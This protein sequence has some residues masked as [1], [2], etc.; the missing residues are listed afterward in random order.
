MREIDRTVR[1]KSGKATVIPWYLAGGVDPTKIVAPYQSIGVA[2]YAASLQNFY[3]PATHALTEA[4]TSPP[5]CKYGGWQFNKDKGLIT[6]INPGGTK[7]TYTVLVRCY[8]ATNTADSQSMLGMYNGNLDSLL[9]FFA[10][11]DMQY[12]SSG[13]YVPAGT[14]GSVG[15]W[16]IAGKRAYLNGTYLGDVSNGNNLASKVLGVGCRGDGSSGMMGNIGF[17]LIANGDLSAQMGAIHTAIVAIE[18]QYSQNVLFDGDSLTFGTQATTVNGL[19]QNYPNQL[20]RNYAVFTTYNSGKFGDYVGYGASNMIA[21]F[22]TE[23]GARYIAGKTNILCVWGGINDITAGVS[24]ADLETNLTTY[25]TAARA[26]GFKV[27]AT[28]IITAGT[29]SGGQQTIRGNVNTWIKANYT[30]LADALCDAD[31]DAKLQ[32]PADTTYF[33]ADTIHLNNTGYGVVAGL[34][35]T[36]IEALLP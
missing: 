16:G 34:M 13:F 5:W 23:I 4:T 27:V 26:A 28:T 17:A 18:N 19:L 2:S 9:L 29:L 22:A 31:G 36:Q 7:Q 32:N 14:H 8:F 11:T 21:D 10:A 6:D 15:T 3:V 12:Y 30:T 35:K 1:A 24:A 25:Y 20:M 33:N